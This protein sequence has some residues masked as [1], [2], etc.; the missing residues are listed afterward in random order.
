MK[1]FTTII[2]SIAFMIGGLMIATSDKVV[3]D[4]PGTMQV[5]ATP[6]LFPQQNVQPLGFSLNQASND[7]IVKTQY[8]HDTVWVPKKEVKFMRVFVTKHKRRKGVLYSP[9][10]SSKDKADR[11]EDTA[12]SMIKNENHSAADAGYTRYD[13]NCPQDSGS[14]TLSGSH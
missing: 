1:K 14:V 4:F 9:S 10:T 7:T 6:Q 2:C 8:V 5:N 3:I 13:C 12:I 11:E